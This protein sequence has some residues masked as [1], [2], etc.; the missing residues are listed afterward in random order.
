MS[1][2]D[3]FATTVYPVSDSDAVNQLPDDLMKSV[4]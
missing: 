2:K 3:L 4:K 1:S